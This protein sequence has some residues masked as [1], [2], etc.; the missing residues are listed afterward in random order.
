MGCNKNYSKYISKFI[1]ILL[2]PPNNYGIYGTYF[3]NHPLVGKPRVCHRLSIIQLR[4]PQFLI[5]HKDQNTRCGKVFM[6][7][8]LVNVL[9]YTSP[10]YCNIW[11]YHLQQIL[12]LV[13]WNIPKP[14]DI[15]QTLLKG[16]LLLP[17]TPYL[18]L[19]KGFVK[20]GDP[21]APK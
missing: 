19:F 2:I 1:Y 8:G 10:T 7:Q 15:Y 12:V 6:K 14:L 18:F 4:I 20:S 3:S 21:K 16:Y 17:R 9:I 5:D 13:M 11:G